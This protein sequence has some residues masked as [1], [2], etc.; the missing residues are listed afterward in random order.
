MKQGVSVDVGVSRKRNHDDTSS[1]V[2]RG[3]PSS[4]MV[5]T[6][7]RG[8][9]QPQF[10]DS[11]LVQ[12]ILNVSG[13]NAELEVQVAGMQHEKDMVAANQEIK[14]LT[15]SVDELKL[16]LIHISEPTRPY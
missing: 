3:A 13:R 16:S 4:K 11:S 1:P 15:K 9:Q 8:P 6:H 5:K 14:R 7:G 12:S 2:R 10:L